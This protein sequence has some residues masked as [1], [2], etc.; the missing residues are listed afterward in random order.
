MCV[1]LK[2]EAG[3]E[4]P[5]EHLLAS[6]YRN[7]H[8]FGVVVL[9]NG[10]LERF[11][12][13]EEDPDKAAKEVEKILGDAKDELAFVHF[14][15][16][17]RGAVDEQN[18]QPIPLLSKKSGDDFDMCFLHN[19][20]I[21]DIKASSPSGG[22]S[23]GL[24]DSVLF[25]N[26]I[27]EPLVRRSAAFR[28]DEHV[29]SD[30]LIPTICRVYGDWSRFALV[31]S[32]GNSLLINEESGTKQ[33][34]GWASNTYSLD[35]KNFEK[36]SE[37]KRVIYE[38]FWPRS[39]PQFEELTR[40]MNDNQSQSQD[41]LRSPPYQRETVNSATGYSLD[42]FHYLSENEVEDM[43]RNHPQLASLLI[44]DLIEYHYTQTMRP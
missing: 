34:Y 7:N 32:L 28:G 37:E 9:A 23:E 30:P 14:R 36:K 41:I 25:A 38:P 35:P 20:T 33:D 27:L 40:K 39:G 6:S 31:D 10:K 19:G 4:V 44:L 11:G 2:K 13:L 17:T 8:G 26:Q 43:T 1:I 16:R 22:L 29:L 42:D 15:F 24:S 3:K 21:S 18:L 5:Y 12:G